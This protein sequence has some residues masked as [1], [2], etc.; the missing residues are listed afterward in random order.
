LLAALFIALNAPRDA[1]L[2]GCFALGLMQDL[3]TQQTLGIYALSYGLVAM[4]VINTQS[5]LYRDHP[6]THISVAFAGSVICA[7]VL[8]LHDVLRLPP[9][10]RAEV[11]RLFYSAIYTTVLSPFLLGALQKIRKAFGFHPRRARTY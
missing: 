3:L 11:S 5:L 9:Q 1:A 8:L 10:E 6:L 2:L 4:F 7:M